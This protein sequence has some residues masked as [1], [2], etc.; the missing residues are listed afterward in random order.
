MGGPVCAEDFSAVSDTTSREP[1]SILQ[2][3][4]L[5]E[6]EVFES[7]VGLTVFLDPVDLSFS[8]TFDSDRW[9]TTVAMRPDGFW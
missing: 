5:P 2:Q 3:V 4:V 8:L 7:I 6:Y 1:G 9:G